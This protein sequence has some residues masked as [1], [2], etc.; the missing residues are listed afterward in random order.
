MNIFFVWFSYSLMRCFREKK[1]ISIIWWHKILDR[2]TL[3]CIYLKRKCWQ[4]A[5]FCHIVQFCSFNLWSCHFNFEMYYYDYD[6]IN[7]MFLL[8]NLS[9]SC[10][11]LINISKG[12]LWSFHIIIFLLSSTEKRQQFISSPHL[13]IASQMWE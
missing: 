10:L 6:H 11:S 13:L 4:V 2:S 8:L 9:F 1:A 7:L 3:F 12:P 5:D